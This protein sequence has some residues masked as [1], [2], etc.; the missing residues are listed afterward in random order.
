[1]KKK[2]LFLIILLLIN[3]SVLAENEATIKNIKVNGKECT[4]SGYDCSIE[5]DAK[6]A[7]VTYELVDSKATVDR[8]SGFS[9]DLISQM[10]VV[11]IVV[12]NQE[13]EEKIE[14]TYSININ[15]HEKS[16]DY[17]LKELKV[18]D[19]SIELKEEV[20]VYN[21]QAGYDDEEIL[22]DATTN[23]L[24]AKI[25]KEESYEFGLDRSSISIDF[26][27]TAEN[28]D[29][30][31]YR[32]FVTR[33]KK[34][35]TT[36]K[37]LKIDKADITFDKDTLEYEISV[38]YSVNSLIIEA[39]PNDEKA[40]VKIEKDDLVVG[41]NI[42]KVIVTNEKA[43]SEY[44]LNV[45]REPNM[46]KS[47]ANLKKLT[48]KEYPNLNFE[49]NVLEYDLKFNELPSKLTIDAAPISS[50]G[51]VEILNNEDL[52]NGDSIFVK[53]TL[54]ETGITREYTL[55]VILNEG[56]SNSKT[57]ILVSIIVLTIVIC[58][59]LFLEIKERKINRKKKLNR[60]KEAKKI[61]DKM[62][63]KK[64]KKDDDIEII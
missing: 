39:I 6:S 23:D 32:I 55:N 47:L 30:K 45:T 48:I 44:I 19:N 50:D 41:E 7:K 14:N 31:T 38:E 56:I 64:L 63:E 60:I 49:E 40:S 15:L 13:N 1:M 24:N 53:V 28:G 37:S 52:E 10:T 61:K 58:I 46:D 16:N 36:L 33:G 34:P 54:N 20:Y 12:S 9:V 25:K 26:D 59:L 3:I 21:Y 18:N 4:C 11:K 22:I 51:R 29:V 27:V 57:F 2:I 35:D 62:K 8:L 42:I 17:S 5:I 43:I